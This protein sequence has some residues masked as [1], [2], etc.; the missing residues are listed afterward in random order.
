MPRQPLPPP[1][2][3][4]FAFPKVLRMEPCDNLFGKVELRWALREY[5]RLLPQSL[6]VESGLHYL[7]TVIASAA[8]SE[9]IQ[10]ASAD[11]FLDCFASLAMTES[12]RRRYFSN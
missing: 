7:H 1:S 8:R 2:A 9:A 12:E 10:G 11:A 4:S 3:E 6:C 5:V